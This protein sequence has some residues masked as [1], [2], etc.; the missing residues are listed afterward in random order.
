MFY[1]I[2]TKE[3]WN[4]TYK[5]LYGKPR[6]AADEETSV[7][8]EW[9][10][11][12]V[13]ALNVHVSQIEITTLKPDD[14]HPYVIDHRILWEKY[15]LV[16]DLISLL[17]SVGYVVGANFSFD[18]KALYHLYGVWVTNCRDIIVMAQMI[19]NATG[20]KFGAAHGHSLYDLCRDWMNVHLEG[21][22][23]KLQ[24]SDW[25]LP[26][27]HRTLD[28]NHWNDKVTYAANDTEYL[29]PIHDQMYL[30]LCNPLPRT[31]LIPDGT[32][33]EDFG[34]GMEEAFDLEMQVI[35][36]TAQIEYNGIPASKQMLSNL[37]RGVEDQLEQLA[38]ELSEYFE[39]PMEAGLDIF[40]DS[41][42]ASEYAKKQLNN[43]VSLLEMIHHKL[44]LGNL[45]NTQT[46]VLERTLEIIDK[47]YS[48]RFSTDS[49]DQERAASIEVVNDDEED[50][51]RQ[52]ETYEK[53][54]IFESTP[55]LKKII[56]YRR[57]KKL[58]GMDLKKYINPATGH[59]HS[60]ISQVGT[61]TYRFSSRSPNVQ[62]VPG[63][64]KLPVEIE[65]DENGEIIP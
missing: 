50:L 15:G 18:L 29:L 4:E 39:L 60:S 54:M 62:Q 21:K 30:V 20:S 44:S 11:K 64:E 12:N 59:I 40:D 57:L 6:L 31:P 52:L 22:G 36:V 35:P 56:R 24:G 10:G 9:R 16:P 51:Y 65:V 63:N 2:D 49:E 61:S 8:D 17:S 1:Y 53:S 26:L 58:E 41:L 7:K 48:E 3:K 37:Q 25:G 19:S 32:D 46:S 43:P 42:Y 45:D 34:L 27:S 38:Y 55:I 14:D 28:N 5:A 33:D 13:T 23:E 47:V